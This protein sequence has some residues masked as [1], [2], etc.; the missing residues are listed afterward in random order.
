MMAVLVE[1]G[2]VGGVG[3]GELRAVDT[4]GLHEAE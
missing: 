3:G 4:R 1:F 2:D